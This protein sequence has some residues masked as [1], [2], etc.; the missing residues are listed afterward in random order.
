VCAPK[1]RPGFAGGNA[2]AIFAIFIIA[3]ILDF[4]TARVILL[5]I[6]TAKGKEIEYKNAQREMRK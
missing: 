5:C 6:K 1:G 3:R 4:F 2:F